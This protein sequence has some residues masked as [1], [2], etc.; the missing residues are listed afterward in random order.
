MT[1]PNVP[2]VVSMLPK[3]FAPKPERVVIC[4]TRLVLSPNSA[5]GVPVVNS[6]LCIALVGSC[7][8]KILLC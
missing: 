3:G 2:Y 8:E 4:A 5:F 6:M 7:V 1:V